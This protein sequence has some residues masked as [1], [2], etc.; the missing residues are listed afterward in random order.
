MQ[1]A[2]FDSDRPVQQFLCSGSIATEWTDS[3]L[4]RL[5]NVVQESF[6]VNQTSLL[7]WCACVGQV[8]PSAA[9][10]RLLRII[11]FSGLRFT[12]SDRV[13]NRKTLDQLTAVIGQAR[14]LGIRQITIDLTYEA[15]FERMP[16]QALERFLTDVG[17]ERVHVTGRD[18]TRYR[19]VTHILSALGYRNIGLDWFLQAGDI[20]L[21]A[22]GAGRLYWSLLGFSDMHSPD[23]IG[24]GPGALS[25]VGEFYGANET[26]WD[27]YEAFLSRGRLP[28]V[29]GV[30]L[31][32]DD[33]LRREIMKMILAASCIRV[34]AIEEKWGIKFK[35][36]FS[37]ETER[38]RGFEQKN[39]VDWQ[40][41]KIV[42]LV[43]GYQELTELCGLF[44]HRRREK[45]PTSKQSIV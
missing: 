21:Q 25:S 1:G 19:P 36:F 17:P 26:R 5:A 39:W 4:Y 18:G 32:A 31:E 12:C 8:V 44:D 34:A 11:G 35:Q 13:E 9:R 40:D 23:V 6:L 30:E 2:L 20:W 22:E 33:V 10:I 15:Q 43:R 28:V 42:I 14:Q 45:L 7:N 41:N 29:R 16:I 24:I 37:Y 38:L 27:L 3:Q